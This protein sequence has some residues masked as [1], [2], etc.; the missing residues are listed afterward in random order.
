MLSETESVHNERVRDRR[1][2]FVMGVRNVLD[3]VL[4][5]GS[6]GDAWLVAA[7]GTW[8]AELDA[9]KVSN[10]VGEAMPKLGDVVLC[11]GPHD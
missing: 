8:L 6:D 11:G 3:Y 9:W 5:H 1:A 7:L 10:K 2:A 4:R